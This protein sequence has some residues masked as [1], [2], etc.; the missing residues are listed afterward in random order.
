MGRRSLR[1]Y[2]ILFYFDVS[3]RTLEINQIDTFQTPS[4]KLT[5]ILNCCKVIICM[6]VSQSYFEILMIHVVLLTS[7]GDSQAGADDFLPHLIYIL[8]KANPPHLA[9]NMEYVS[10]LLSYAVIDPSLGLL[11]ITADPKL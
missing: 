3:N 7:S 4:D 11:P 8:I 5:C 1:Y 9:S 10:I 6:F 2:F